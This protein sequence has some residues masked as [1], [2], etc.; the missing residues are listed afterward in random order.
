MV[1]HR[2]GVA[3]FLASVMLFLLV[4]AL[5]CSFGSSTHDRYQGR[6]A[7]LL[8]FALALSAGWFREDRDTPLEG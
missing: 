6:V 4:N 8:P 2:R 5:V 7:W 3:F 1:C